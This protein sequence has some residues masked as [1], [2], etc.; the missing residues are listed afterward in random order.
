MVSYEW[1][2]GV[3]IGITGHQ[4][5]SD[6]EWAWVEVALRR[7][8]AANVSSD[9]VAWSSLAVG[10]DQLFARLALA[11]GVRVHVVVPFPG[12]E[13]G[14]KRREDLIAYGDLLRAASSTETLAAQSSSEAS[15]F[16]AGKHIVDH[17]RLLLAVWDEHPPHGLGGTADVV[18]YALKS[19][20]RTA[21]VNPVIR[22]VRFEP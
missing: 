6:D 13:N 15:Y 1:W 9:T 22:L 21:I 12:Y 20:R 19:R 18:A 14:F 7:L 4:H 3:N 2:E 8:L 17:T 10:A 11:S 16:E 5:L